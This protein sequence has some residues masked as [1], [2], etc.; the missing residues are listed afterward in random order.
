MTTVAAR[1]RSIAWGSLATWVALTIVG[2]TFLILA[3][4]VPTLPT[5]FGPKGFTI[6]F[7]LTLG[8]VGAL[9]ALKRP[10]NPIGWILSVLGVISA[11]LG[12]ATEYARW[13]LIVRGG[14]PGGGPTAAWLVEWGWIPL[15]GGLAMIAAIFP[16]GRFLSRRWRNAVVVA[17]VLAAIPMVLTALIPGLTVYDGVANPVGIGGRG[18]L[19]LA[20][21]S[22]SLLMPLFVIATLSA[23]VRFRRVRGDERQQLKWLVFAMLVVAAMLAL[24]S[25]IAIV[26]GTDDPEAF[27]WAEYLMIFG[28]VS[29]PISI[30]FGVLKYRLYDIDL[31]INK[32]VVY[33]AIAVF[34][35]LVYVGVVVG[36]GALVGRS[37][38]T[39]PSAVAAAV[40]AIAFQPVRRR[41][42]GIANRV[43]YGERATPYE[44]L[45]QLGD[46]LAGEYASDDVLDRVA[47]T[48]A[49]GIGAERVVVWLHV[50]TELRPAAAW[51]AGT[52]PGAAVGGVV[53]EVP[54]EIAGMRAFPARHQG[55]LLGAIAVDK[56]ASDPITEADERLVTDLAGQAGLV[57]RNVRLIEDLRASR[58]RLVAAQDL[59]RR[60]IERNIHDGAQQQLVA[61][62]VKMRL[63]DGMI[64]RDEA[65]AHELL[66]QLQAET[67]DASDTLRD[68]ARGIYPPLLAD[69]G[70]VAALEAQA[71]KSA[72]PVEISPD[73]VTRY[74]QEI[75]AATYFCVLKAIQNIAKYANATRARVE[76]RATDGGL[77]F[78][79]EDDG[80]GFDDNARRGSGLTNMQDRVDALG[81][82][83]DV[84]SAPGRGTVVAGWLPLEVSVR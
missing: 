50:G 46:R 2:L 44:V 72:V 78:T 69:Q 43:V 38:A 52:A 83:I 34:I 66:A 53:D 47:S 80:I 37:G 48:L 33:G 56:P 21:A 10:E 49:G 24:Y 81:G 65:R 12:I 25:V 79:V 15:V 13:A 76:L 23:I 14:A 64:G 60:R 36:I 27:D 16:D 57:L 82:R 71:R 68:L 40:V 35:T 28:F 61:M 29:V 1:S 31:V 59:E 75:E 39:F 32:A 17:I 20:E 63:A 45:A 22:T 7:T 55:E 42:Q 74:P 6:P 58:Q 26:I 5:E 19:D 67:T 70:L 51:P 18:M 9:L 30:G 8:G 54:A 4:D 73:G 77:A 62:A 41:A 84:R 3:W 11:I